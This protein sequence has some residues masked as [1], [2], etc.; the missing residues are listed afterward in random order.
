MYIIELS[1]VSN[2]VLARLVCYSVSKFMLNIRIQDSISY[3]IDDIHQPEFTNAYISF[4]HELCVKYTKSTNTILG[5]TILN[6]EK[7][8]KDLTE[9]TVERKNRGAHTDRQRIYT[10]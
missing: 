3:L 1:S 2:E 10:H 7:H 6:S 8:Q 5:V 9:H 4:I